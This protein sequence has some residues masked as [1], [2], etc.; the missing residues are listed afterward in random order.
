MCLPG[1]MIRILTYYHN[2]GAVKRAEIES[3]ENECG[4]REDLTGAILI[5]Y[6][7]CEPDKVVFFKLPGQFYL[8]SS[9]QFLHPFGMTSFKPTQVVLFFECKINRAEDAEESPQVIQPELF[10]A[11]D[12]NSKKCKDRE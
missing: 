9:V 7:F 3:I 2:P 5:P 6:K 10:G 1:I 4:R 8:S 11:E 12:N